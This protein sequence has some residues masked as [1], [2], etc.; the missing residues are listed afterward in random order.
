ML[1]RIGQ[2]CDICNQPC[3]PKSSK[4]KAVGAHLPV[5]R[6]SSLL[7]LVKRERERSNL[8][9]DLMQLRTDGEKEDKPVTR[10]THLSRR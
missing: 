5:K 3:D 4:L 9:I 7:M 8:S 6:K 1:E 2:V 10:P